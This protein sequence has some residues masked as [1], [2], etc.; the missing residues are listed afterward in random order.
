[1][2]EPAVPAQSPPRLRLDQPLSVV[3]GAGSVRGLAHV[4]I[5]AVLREAGFEIAEIAGTSVGAIVAAFYAAV[6][7]DLNQIRDAGLGL[8]TRQ[9]LGWALLRHASPATR[10]RWKRIAGV[11]PDHIERLSSG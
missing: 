9:L 7:L 3:L 6:G 5:L 4:A 2:G 1:M 8:T 10:Q 11:I